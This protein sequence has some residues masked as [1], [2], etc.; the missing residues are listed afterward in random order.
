MRKLVIFLILY[1]FFLSGCQVNSHEGKHAEKPVLAEY[2]FKQ[3]ENIQ[4]EIDQAIVRAVEADKLFLLVLGAQWCH[5]SRG[6]AQQFSTDAM[7]TVLEQRF[8]TVFVDVGY[9]QDLRELTAQYGYPGYFA[10]PSVMVIDP[11]TKQHLN[12]Q[13]MAMWNAADS[14]PSDEVIDYFKTV[15]LESSAETVLSVEKQAQLKQVED[16]A[17]TETARLFSGFEQLGP[18]VQLAV[19]GDL[20]DD[21][22]L[23]ALANEIYEFRMTLQ[24]D[25]HRLHKAVKTS[26]KDA[27]SVINFPKYGPFSWES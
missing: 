6:L 22:Q 14:V 12:M 15:G 19:D 17:Y 13:S 1:S 27:S 20:A 25:I 10:T 11:N 4:L 8:E 3:R 24:K 7:Q 18:M 16:F 5:D 9:Y 26:S 21:T 23:R 2:E